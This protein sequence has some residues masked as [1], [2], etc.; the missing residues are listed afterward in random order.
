[1]KNYFFYFQKKKKKN[2]RKAGEDSVNLEQSA[3][4]PK[5]ENKNIANRSKISPGGKHHTNPSNNKKVLQTYKQQTKPNNLVNPPI[6]KTSPQIN[7][8]INPPNTKPASNG[9]A[10]ETEKKKRRTKKRGGKGGSTVV[11]NGQLAK[12]FQKTVSVKPI[13]DDRS[14]DNFKFNFKIKMTVQFLNLILFSFEF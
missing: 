5:L 1:M 14:R 11:P 3:K 9:Q 8:S 10:E 2:K 7:N 6:K 4:R 13:T 12:I